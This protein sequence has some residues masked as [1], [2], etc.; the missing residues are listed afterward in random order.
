MPRRGVKALRQV[1]EWRF[2]FGRRAAAIEGGV[3]ILCGSTDASGSMVTFRRVQDEED[4]RRC[5]DVRLRVFVEEQEVPASEELDAYD[6]VAEHFLAE[7]RGCVLGTARMVDLGDGVGKIGRVA[8]LR[9]WRGKGIG[10]AL[11]EFVL[12]HAEG[13]FDVLILD[14]QV[15]VIAFYEKLGFEAEGEV[16]L[17]AGIPHR[18]M[19]RAFPRS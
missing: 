11:M 15:P 13:R 3:Q 5:L 9:E 17:D 16:F 10:R 18:R 6:A 4:L 14:A 8:V 2:E 19:R 7:C 1:A 12:A